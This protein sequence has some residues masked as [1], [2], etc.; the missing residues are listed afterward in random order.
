LAADELFEFGDAD[1]ITIVEAFGLEDGVQSFEDSGLPVGQEVGLDVVL[2]TEFGL[3][4]FT[5]QELE[6]DL[7][8]ELSRKGPT[9]TRHD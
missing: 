8:L 6:H 5:P 3:T 9:R 4:G 1:Q 7:G 2:A